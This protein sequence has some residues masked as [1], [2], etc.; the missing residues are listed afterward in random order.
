MQEALTTVHTLSGSSDSFI[1]AERTLPR[2]VGVFSVF[3]C[4]SDALSAAELRMVA[5]VAHL[6][7][8]CV[9]TVA[10]VLYV[11]HALRNELLSV[12]GKQV[13][14]PDFD[15]YMRHH[16][17]AAFPDERAPKPWCYAVTRD[18]QHYP[19]GIVSIEQL[20]AGRGTELLSA[21]SEPAGK[22]DVSFQVRFCVR[23]WI[24]APLNRM[25][26]SM[27]PRR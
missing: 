1:V 6:R 27:L 13:A 15:D 19:E 3:V 16:C 7:K 8:L 5:L 9:D 11:E 25:R 12:I 17:R 23:L 10:C 21:F 2:G 4:S 26:S 14:A 22:H 20:T 18:V 24:S